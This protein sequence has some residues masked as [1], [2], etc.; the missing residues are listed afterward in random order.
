MCTH[1]FAYMCCKNIQ[2]N[3]SNE[4]MHRTKLDPMGD[5]SRECVRQANCMV[6]R[7]TLILWLHVAI[8]VLILLENPSGS[9]LELHDRVKH[10]RHKCGIFKICINLQEFGSPS[11]KP[12]WIY[13][14]F[15]WVSEILQYKTHPYQAGQKKKQQ[16]KFRSTRTP[17]ACL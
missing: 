5:S 11:K 4:N 16:R 2:I 6:S 12:L 7:T 10:W 15:A 1:R 17:P 8:G 13:S 14:Q 3:T 9:L